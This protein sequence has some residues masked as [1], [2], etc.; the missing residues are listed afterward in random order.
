M[1]DLDTPAQLRLAPAAQLTRYFA[2]RAESLHFYRRVRGC[3]EPPPAFTKEHVVYH[4]WLPG[5]LD[6]DASE[7]ETIRRWRVEGGAAP[8]LPAE[9]AGALAARGWCAQGATPDLDQLLEKAFTVFPAIQNPNELR[10]FLDEVA[11]RRPRTAVEIGTAAGGVLYC[12]AQLA[13]PDALLIGIDTP[14]GPYGGGQDEEEWELFSTFVGPGQRLE[15]IR[16]RS[17]HQSTKLDLAGLLGGRKVNLLFIDGDHSYGGARSDLEMYREF[18][19]PDGLIV[20]H[21]IMMFPETWGR[22]FDVGILWR[23]LTAIHRTREIIDRN[24]PFIPPP[25]EEAERW[26]MPALGFGLLLA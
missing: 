10:L 17:F 11:L 21:D 3:G 9:L 5:F 7:A 15:S 26:G 24:A 20:F 16:D 4:S 13:A 12:L 1:A 23:E 19:A 25:I 22:G 8:P 18:V 6:V 2:K 14:E